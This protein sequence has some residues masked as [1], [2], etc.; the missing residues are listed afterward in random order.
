MNSLFGLAPDTQFRRC[1]Q[2]AAGL[3]EGD[4]VDFADIDR[5][6]HEERLAGVY[7]AVLEMLPDGVMV[8][9]SRAAP[10]SIWC[11]GH[12]LEWRFDGYRPTG[13]A[14]RPAEVLVITARSIVGVLRA[15]YPV[16]VHSSATR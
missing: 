5:V 10:P 8:Q 6:L 1:W 7:P 15:G 13:N 11:R 2:R 9:S 4:Q 16:G 3:G 12:L 14:S